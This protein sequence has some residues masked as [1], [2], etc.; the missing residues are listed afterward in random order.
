MKGFAA[1]RVVNIIRNA[2]AHR[3]SANAITKLNEI[4]TARSMKIAS[5]AV[6][7]AENYGRK[8]IKETDIKLAHDQLS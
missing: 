8:T 3:V 6:K 4:I 2:G 5:K 7:I 1:A